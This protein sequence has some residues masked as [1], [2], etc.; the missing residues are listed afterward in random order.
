VGQS[1]APGTEP[2]LAEQWQGS[3]WSIQA[4]PHPAAATESYLAGV[5]CP[6]PG[7]CRAGGAAFFA[8]PV[9]KTLAEGD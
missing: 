5:S 6:S 2:T 1:L 8:G 7:A 4:T 9:K 3:S